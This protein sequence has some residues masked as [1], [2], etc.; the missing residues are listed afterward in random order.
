LGCSMLTL[1]KRSNESTKVDAEY[2]L[3]NNGDE[4]DEGGH[5]MGVWS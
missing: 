3:G 4:G 2:H 5:D 1:E